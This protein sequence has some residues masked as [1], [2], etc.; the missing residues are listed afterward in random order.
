VIARKPLFST[1][2]RPYRA[3]QKA[4][5]VNRTLK[6]VLIAV[7]A[8]IGVVAVGGGAFVAVQVS[9][10]ESS[11]DRVYAVP[12]PK[13][14]RSTDAA[15][16]ERGQHLAESVAACATSDCHGADLGGGKTIEAGPIGVFTGPNVSEG[17]LGAAYSDG[18]LFRL[19]RNGLKK[20]G[21][22]VRFMPSHE[23][24]WLP[25]A[26]IVAIVSYL[27]S[28]PAVQKPSGPTQIATFGKVLDRQDLFVADVAR[29]IDHEKPELAGAPTPDARY[30]RFLAKGCI[31][32]HGEGLSGGQIP[33]TPPDFPVPT[34]LT[35]H[36]SGL[37]DWSFADFERLLDT[38]KRKNGTQLDPFMPL[39][40]LA[41]FDATERQALWA[42]LRS[43]PPR[44]FGER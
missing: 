12:V 41:K 21:R 20:D 30:G 10:Y 29:R 35:P 2:D 3:P 33:G 44:A 39:A 6:R 16:L 42:Y 18:E 25:D 26:D 23:I 19:I 13:V 32:C 38:G 36:P 37:Q 11:M 8:L 14:T 15:V 27:R 43:V 24:G 7:G 4:K 22:S 34:N 28:R 1:P 40:A 9:R 5:F 17:G 31:G